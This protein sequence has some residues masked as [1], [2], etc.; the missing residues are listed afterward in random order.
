MQTENVQSLRRD[1]IV[2]ADHDHDLVHDMGKRLDAVWRYDEYIKN[3][4]NRNEI[5]QFW[6]DV[7]TQD[8]KNI[9]RLKK[10]MAKEI[11]INCF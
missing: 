2:M 1:K 9:E 3:A 10:L 7:K 4:N 8:M 6:E 5:K 11:S